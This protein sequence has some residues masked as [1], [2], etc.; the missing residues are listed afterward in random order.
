VFSERHR[1]R[2]LVR[3][4][5]VARGQSACDHADRIAGP[6]GEIG[7]VAGSQSG[8]DCGTNGLAA[9]VRGVDVVLH[10]A[11]S[12]RKGSLPALGFS[13]D[14]G[15]NDYIAP[16]AI[17]SANLQGTEH[18]LRASVGR[19]CGAGGCGRGVAGLRPLLRGRSAKI[20]KAASRGL[21]NVK[22]D[23]EAWS[24]SEFR[25]D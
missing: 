14:R 1:F 23:A 20:S 13:A 25:Q 6:V 16:G 21:C 11:W 15:S 9:A 4:P 3:A 7:A 12:S 5:M 19:V 18:L 10:L 8:G 2:S 17:V 22:I 24:V